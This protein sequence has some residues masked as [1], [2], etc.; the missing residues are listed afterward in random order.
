MS[1]SFC[2]FTIFIYFTYFVAIEIATKSIEIRAKNEALY[3][4]Q[5]AMGALE[6]QKLSDELEK[7]KSRYALLEIVAKNA[8]IESCGTAIAEAKVTLFLTCFISWKYNIQYTNNNRQD[9]KVCSSKEKVKL[10]LLN[11]ELMQRS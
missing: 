9:P 1:S 10:N 7:E 3:E 2:F 4:H 5:K 8:A 6:I 11:S